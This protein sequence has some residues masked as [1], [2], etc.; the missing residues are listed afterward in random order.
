MATLLSKKLVILLVHMPIYRENYPLL[1]PY[2]GRPQYEILVGLGFPEVPPKV[3]C[4]PCPSSAQSF[5]QSGP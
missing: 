1:E 2:Q 3:P 5:S 4:N